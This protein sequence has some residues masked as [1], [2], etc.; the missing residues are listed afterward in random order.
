[1]PGVYCTRCQSRVILEQDGVSCSN[2]K[3]ILVAPVQPPVGA[4]PRDRPPK[5]K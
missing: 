2:C 5:E 4:D 1:M 3:A